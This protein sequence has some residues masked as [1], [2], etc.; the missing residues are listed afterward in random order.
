MDR[1]LLTVILIEVETE[2]WDR[3]ESVLQMPGTKLYSYLSSFLSYR[4]SKFT[5]TVILTFCVIFE[6]TFLLINW[7]TVYNV[8]FTVSSSLWATIMTSKRFT[9]SR[10]VPE[11]FWFKDVN[12][13]NFFENNDHFRSCISSSGNV[14]T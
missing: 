7:K 2:R 6:G 11:I 8:T 10:F 5:K 13:V 3:S 14:I 1:I 9:L 4:A 12:S